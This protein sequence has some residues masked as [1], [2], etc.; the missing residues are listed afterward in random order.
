MGDTFFSEPEV[1]TIET[2]K[3]GAAGLVTKRDATG[4]AHSVRPATPLKA[5][6]AVRPPAA[7]SPT[8]TPDGLSRGWGSHP[9]GG[10]GGVGPPPIKL[11]DGIWFKVGGRRLG[12]GT[13]AERFTSGW[14]YHRIRYAQHGGV[15]V[16]RTDVVPDGVRA[17]LIGLTLRSADARRVRLVVDA[18]SELLATYPWG[19]TTPDQLTYNLDDD[20][21]FDPASGR[22]VFTEQGTPP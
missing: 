3:P 5:P 15:R 22:L 13:P 2:P 10:M 20:G 6:P 4:R 14:G 21:A 1:R 9:R 11:L 19:E 18:H 17:G 16:E 7:H 12:D 8:S